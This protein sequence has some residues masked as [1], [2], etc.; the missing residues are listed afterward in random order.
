M[1]NKRIVYPKISLRFLG[2]CIDF[3]IFGVLFF[4]SSTFIFKYI[5]NS[6]D[7]DQIVAKAQVYSGLLIKDKNGYYNQLNS[8]DYIKYQE[9]VEN[10]YLTDKYFGSSFYKENGGERSCYKVEE[11][12]EK[13]LQLG[14]DYTYFEYQYDENGKIDTSKIGVIKAKY[15]E[16]EDKTKDL[17]DDA[18]ADLLTFYSRHYREIFSDLY[19]D[20]FY[21]IARNSIVQKGV[22]RIFFSAF[23]P[24][25][26]VFVI[27]PVTNKYGFT[28][29]R[30]LTK[31]ALV[32]KDGLYQKGWNSLFIENHDQRRS[33]GRFGT[34]DQKYRVESSKMLATFYFF[35]QGTPFIYQG[36]EIGTTNAYFKSIDE[37]KDVE[38]KNMFNLS[39]KNKL[40]GFL[41]KKYI[42]EVSRDNARIPMAWDDSSYGGFSS[43]EPWIRMNSNYEKINVKNAINDSNSVFY[44]YQ[45]IIEI[46]KKYPV[47]KDGK[48][49]TIL[50]HSNSIFAYLRKDKKH[51]L[52][53]LT[54]FKNKNI[55][56]TKK[57]NLCDY[58][59]LIS[60]YME[61]D[62]NYLKPYEARVYL[63][64]I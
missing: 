6:Y 50:K 52:L 53:V 51:T 10:Y 26:L 30:F 54:N 2:I 55:K 35:L 11:Y 56:L 38:A 62:D 22:Y 46:R 21:E 23:I 27:P 17:T 49:I 32:S 61:N 13:I 59:L 1:E 28:L 8:S 25:F 18:K 64:E 4:I 47:I 48:Y 29:G 40:I 9:V 7:E 63:K 41:I 36:Q 39:Q 43:V 14:T 16:D 37:I 31:V 12:N 15:Y 3:I 20:S 45:K 33:V 58:K 19:N 5:F 42:F 60:N 34:C 57:L 44:Y 24:Y